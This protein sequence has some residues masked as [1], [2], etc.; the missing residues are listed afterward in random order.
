MKYKADQTVRIKDKTGNMVSGTVVSR[1]EFSYL[2]NAY[3]VRY[4][5]AGYTEVN[6]FTGDTLDQWNLN[7]TV[8]CTCGASSVNSDRH[9]HFCDII[10][11]VIPWL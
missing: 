5:E 10:T 8:N 7:I 6:V 4:S 2:D 11:S 3:W 9:S 1:A